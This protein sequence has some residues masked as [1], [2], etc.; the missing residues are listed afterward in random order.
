MGPFLVQS[1]G[2]P[3]VAGPLL[4]LPLCKRANR[5]LLCLLPLPL[6]QPFGGL[7]FMSF[8]KLTDEPLHKMVS[9]E[10]APKIYATVVGSGV[11]FDNGPGFADGKNV[12][13]QV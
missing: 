9:R 7:Q 10:T 8:A 5:L 11:N 4:L 1:A 13:P 2:L 12:I 6:T 3:S